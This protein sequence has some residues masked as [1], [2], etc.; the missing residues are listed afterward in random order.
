MGGRA[1]CAAHR[2]RRSTNA[3][4]PPRGRPRSVSSAAWMPAR[5]P[6]FLESLRPGERV[7]ERHSLAHLSPQ[8]R[9][10]LLQMA[11]GRKALNAY[12]A[13][14]KRTL[15]SGLRR[16][17]PFQPLAA[18]GAGRAR[19]RVPRGG[20]HRRFG[21][22][23]MRSI[24]RTGG[25]RRCAAG[26]PPAEWSFDR[27]GVEAHVVTHTPTCAPISPRR[28][29][30]SRRTRFWRPPTIP[31]NCCWRPRCASGARTIYLARATLALPFGPDCAFPSAAKTDVLAPADA[32]V[33]VS[34]YV[35]DYIRKW[36][37][38]PAVH[39][40]ISLLDPPPYPDLGRFENEF[41]TLVNPCA[42]KGIS[43]FLELADAFP[44]S[45]IRGRADM[46]HHRSGPRGA[47]RACQHY[48][49]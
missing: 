4:R 42:V 5:M 1:A 39:V 32:V 44:Q 21:G 2:S 48:A 13:G 18:G 26:R 22:R 10:L 30:P 14:A 23:S 16:R 40:P 35:A 12:P 36:S 38:I 20:A 43:I 34:Q 15:L 6:E 8:K 7:P 47:R 9:T 19:P 29:R 27:A 3:C 49:A 41:V 45:A 28:P 24:W 17:R 46:G 11:R 31:R 33:G 37:G 25:A